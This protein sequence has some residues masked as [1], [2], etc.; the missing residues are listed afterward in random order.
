MA[1]SQ[2]IETVLNDEGNEPMQ[3]KGHV[4]AR[5]SA[6]LKMN[7]LNDANQEA[8]R[9]LVSLVGLSQPEL[10]AATKRALR[11]E[12]S[13]I[14]NSEFG[15]KDLGKKLFSHPLGLAPRQAELG[16]AAIR[17]SGIDMP[18]HLGRLFEAPLL[19]PEQE[20]MLFQRKNY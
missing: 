20:K 15:N 10:R 6:W 14:G 9:T 19:N 4:R 3:S 2:S 18:I 17:R 12:I 16:I 11:D 1:A 5:P 7:E 8:D 13:F